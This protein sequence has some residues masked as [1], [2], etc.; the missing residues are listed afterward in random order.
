MSAYATMLAALGVE[1]VGGTGAAQDAALRKRN[2]LNVDQVAILL[3]H[4]GDRLQRFEADAGVDHDVAAHP[5]RAIGDAQLELVAGA[6]VHGCRS[7]HVAVLDF[8]ALADVEAG[9][10]GD[11]GPPCVA[12][13]AGVEMDMAFDEA[14]NHELPAKIDNL[15]TGLRSDLRADVSDLALCDGDC[16]RRS[17]GQ[18]EIAEHFIDR[19]GHGLAP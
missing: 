12:I 10:V 8:D 4:R 7:R 16:R 14:G 18:P 15:G 2:Q 13:E 3:A 9:S 1:K 6:L 11:V 17:V 19:F 5:R